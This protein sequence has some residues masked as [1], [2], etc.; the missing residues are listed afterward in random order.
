MKNKT[1]LMSVASVVFV[2]GVILVFPVMHWRGLIGAFLIAYAYSLSNL[3]NKKPNP[4]NLA[5]D[6][7]NLL[8]KKGAEHER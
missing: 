2:L 3:C 8:R 5:E 1:A 4:E 6:L 7:V